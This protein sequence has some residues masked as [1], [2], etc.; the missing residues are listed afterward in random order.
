MAYTFLKYTENM[1][2]GKSLFDE[3]GF[4]LVPE[5]LSLAK[6]HNVSIYLPVDFKIADDF[7]NDA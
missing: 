7:K 1:K 4:K 5:L 2:I 3:A 6:E